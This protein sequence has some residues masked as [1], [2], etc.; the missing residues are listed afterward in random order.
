[1]SD[2]TGGFIRFLEVM[3][4]GRERRVDHI[5]LFLLGASCA[6]FQVGYLD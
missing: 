4:S 6:F 3:G 2:K 5:T 1:M